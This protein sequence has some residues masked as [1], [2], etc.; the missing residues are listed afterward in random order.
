MRAARTFALGLDDG[1]PARVRCAGAGRAVRLARRHRPRARQRPGGD[2][3]AARARRRRRSTP[4]RSRRRVAAVREPGRVALLG[5]HEVA[6]GDDDLVLH[7]R[8][9]LP[10]HPNGMR[11]SAFD[12]PTTL[13]CAS[14]RT[15]R[16]AAGSSSTSRRRAPTGSRPTTPPLPLPVHDRRRAARR[17]ARESG[18][19]ISGVMLANE[20]GVA[21]ART[22]SAPGCSSIWAVM[23]ECVQ[24][25]LRAR[26]ARCR[27]G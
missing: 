22:R 17:G 12:A 4:P 13:C 18:L 14:A 23:Q 9:Q 25:R 16:S 19:P 26:R 15:T 5:K 1:R 3:R 20:T 24:Q 8:Q 2:P 6:L 11:F 7:R 10:F 27:A 21:H